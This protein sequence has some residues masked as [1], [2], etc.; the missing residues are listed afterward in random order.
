ML[1]VAASIPKSPTILYGRIEKVQVPGE[2]GAHLIASDM[3]IMGNPQIITYL[4]DMG[5]TTAMLA[6]MDGCYCDTSDFVLSTVGNG[7]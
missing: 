6:V 5:L 2:I 7:L 4:T 1:F 3:C